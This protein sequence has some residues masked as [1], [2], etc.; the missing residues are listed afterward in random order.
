[1]ISSTRVDEKTLTRP[2]LRGRIESFRLHDLLTL[3]SV[4][5]KTGSLIVTS[6]S[7]EAVILFK[8]GS[9][10]FARSNQ[11]RLRLRQILVGRKR[12]TLEDASQIES[13]ML[14]TA[15][16]FGEIAIRHGNITPDDLVA[17]LKIQTSEIIYDVFMWEQ[18]EF[19]FTETFDLPDYAVE[20]KI[21]VA[22][23]IMEG[24]RRIDEWNMCTALLPD[25]RIVFRM[26]RNPETQEKISLSKDEWKVLFHIDGQ[27]SL[28]E[29]V[30]IRRGDP[31]ELYRIVYGLLANK[32]IEEAPDQRPTMQQ[33]PVPAPPPIAPQTLAS[34]KTLIETTGRV[35]PL[36]IEE[37]SDSEWRR[38]QDDDTHLL[39]SE[40]STMSYREVLAVAESAG[41]LVYYTAEKGKELVALVGETYTIGR[42]TASDIRLED[43]GA[44]SLHA[45]LEK[46]EGSYQIIDLGSHN[47]TWVNRKQIDRQLLRDGD[48][49]YIGRTRMT[50]NLVLNL[51]E[52]A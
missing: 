36:E 24:A 38:L 5:G 14:E 4:A 30:E 2:V 3:M 39:V 45:R 48:E 13:V 26:S 47:G 8:L 23:L 27:R 10:K 46:A 29:L 40:S 44:S 37:I 9:L 22:N 41:R 28:G 19:L 25:D 49:I 33:T 43:V 12:L 21:D 6:E 11:D 1:M 50:F 31:L 34:M 7:R 52:E 35:T 20:I 16:K 42:G 18:G 32:L 15:E 51:P 17:A